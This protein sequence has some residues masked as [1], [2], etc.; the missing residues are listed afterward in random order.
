M[1]I[2]SRADC[3]TSYGGVIRESMVCAGVVDKDSCNGDSGGPLFD[4]STGTL[5]GIV[6]WGQGCAQE[7]FP[8]V[9]SRVGLAVEWINSIL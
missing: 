3:S 5:I 2:V 9:Y 4:G 1:P 7:G 8:G 6:S